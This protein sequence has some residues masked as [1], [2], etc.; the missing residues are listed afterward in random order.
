MKRGQFEL[1]FGMIF[2]IILIVIFVS[3]AFYAIGKFLDIQNSTSVGKFATD[4]QTDI[5]KMWKS[6]QGM[7]E[8]TYSLPEKIKDVCFI[9]YSTPAQG[10]YSSF[11]TEL[12][13][14]YYENENMFFYPIGAAQG[15]NAKQMKNIDLKKTTLIE[16][17]SCFENKNGKVRFVIKKNFNEALVTIGK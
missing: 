11:Y 1:S 7:Q 16:N 12:Q 4:F 5:D 9:D 10:Q 3:F 6:S 2:S 15:L 13:Q 8:E 14:N 17:P